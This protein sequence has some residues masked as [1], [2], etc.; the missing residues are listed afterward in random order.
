MPTVLHRSQITHTASIED[1]LAIGAQEWP[2]DADRPAALLASLAIEGARA[3][4]ERRRAP[5]HRVIFTGGTAP[6]DLDAAEA[7]LAYG[8]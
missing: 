1:A 3:I 4:A 7:D 2:Q 8:W 6:V 5:R